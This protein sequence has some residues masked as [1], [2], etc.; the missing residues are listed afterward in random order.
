MR[1]LGS[2]VNPDPALAARKRATESARFASRRAAAALVPADKQGGLAYAARAL[3]GGRA[4]LMELARLSQ[5]SAVKVIVE[6]WDRRSRRGRL[7]TSL[8]ALCDGAGV[9]P[10]DFLGEVVKAAF[11]HN[12]DVAKLVMAVNI[13][14]VVQNSVK[15]ALTPKGFRDREMLMQATGIAPR[16]GGGIHVNTTAIAGA[17][18]NAVADQGGL[19]AFERDATL[20]AQAVRETTAE[21]PG[22]ETGS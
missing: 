12:T 6:E 11:D 5:H 15:A 9:S 4:S 13:P 7:S 17:R 14:R 21:P 18:A 10:G 20:I 16:G 8:E 1:K 3:P 19:P 22:E 2:S